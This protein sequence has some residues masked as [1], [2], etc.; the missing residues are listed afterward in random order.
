MKKATYAAACLVLFCMCFAGCEKAIDGL[1]QREMA[2][3]EKQV[4]QDVVKQYE[5]A[6]RGGDKMDKCV[7][8][9]L[10]AAAFLQAK[11]EANY[12]KWKAIEKSDCAAVGM[13]R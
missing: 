12:S 6:K 1:A 3:I 7:H 8:A 2:K 10:V 4:A 5:I 11:D 13:P 9:G